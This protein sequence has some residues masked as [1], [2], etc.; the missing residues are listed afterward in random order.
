MT[1]IIKKHYQRIAHS[2]LEGFDLVL[3]VENVESEEAFASQVKLSSKLKDTISSF[4]K[5]I[6]E[7]KT[8]KQQAPNALLRNIAEIC[9]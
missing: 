9:M 5:Y 1:P 4:Q 8:S 2:D 3:S 6:N 7:I